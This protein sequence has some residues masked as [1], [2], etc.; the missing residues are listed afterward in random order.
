MTRRQLHQK[1]QLFSELTQILPGKLKPPIGIVLGS[2]AEVVEVVASLPAADAV[3][4]QM[5]LYQAERLRQELA[6]R[7]LPASVVTAADLWDLPADFA[8]LIYPVPYAGERSLK[9]DM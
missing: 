7:N 5:D 3:C 8:T 1:K 4:Y 9:I 2:P 6:E